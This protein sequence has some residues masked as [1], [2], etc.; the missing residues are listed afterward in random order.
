MNF[1]EIGDALINLDRIE[2]MSCHNDESKIQRKHYDDEDDN[3]SVK[4]TGDPYQIHLQMAGGATEIIRYKNELKRNQKYTELCRL[5][6][7]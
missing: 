3:V 5:L 2:I 6:A 1:Q 4:I 7:K